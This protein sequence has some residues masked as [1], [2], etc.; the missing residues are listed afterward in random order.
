VADLEQIQVGDIVRVKQTINL[1]PLDQRAPSEIPAGIYGEVIDIQPDVE[2]ELVCWVEFHE[3][4][5]YI[6][7]LGIRSECLELMFRFWVN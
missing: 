6:R 3:P 2:G 5:D 4:Y 1:V 7:D